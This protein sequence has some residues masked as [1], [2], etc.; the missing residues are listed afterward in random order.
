MT[1]YNMLISAGL[2]EDIDHHES[3]LY[4]YVSP[5]STAVIYDW[6]KENGY[7]EKAFLSTF[8]DQMTGRTMYDVPFQYDPWWVDRRG[9]E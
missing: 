1:L 3:D 9:C 7:S 8:T 2:A 4:V 5:K 6:L